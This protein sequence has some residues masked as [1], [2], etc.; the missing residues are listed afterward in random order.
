MVS[1]ERLGDAPLGP[2]MEIASDIDLTQSASA[3]HGA[4]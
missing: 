1:T 2:H 4:R 3:A